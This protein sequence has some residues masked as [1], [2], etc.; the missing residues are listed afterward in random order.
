MNID[1]KLLREDLFPGNTSTYQRLRDYL[2]EGRVTGFTGAGVSVPLYPSW[3]GLLGQLLAEAKAAGTLTQVDEVR[4]CESLLHR[5]PLELADILEERIT[6]KVFRSRL[7]AIFRSANDKCTECQTLIA[8]LDLRG[9]VTLNYDSGHE[10][11]YAARGRNPNSGTAQSEFTLTR[12]AQDEVFNDPDT[13]ILHLHGERSDPQ[14]MVLTSTDYDTFYSKSL[15][16]AFISHLWRA[17]RLLAIGFGFSDPFLTRLA[18]GTLRTLPSDTRHYALIGQGKDQP[19]SGLTRSLFVKK[20]RLEP[21]FYEILEHDDDGVPRQDHSNLLH[22]LNGLA[23]I[24]SLYAKKNS[25]A[26]P[27]ARVTE[28]SEPSR[29]IAEKEFASD[30]FVAPNGTTLYSEPRFHSME[31]LDDFAAPVEIP[32]IEL[33][34]ENASYIITCRPEHGATTVSRRLAKELTQLG[35]QACLRDATQ[36]PNYKKKLEE[37]FSNAGYTTASSDNNVLILDRVEIVN[38]ERLIREI[39]GTGL[40]SRLFLLVS[41][42]LFETNGT[43]PSDQFDVCFKVVSLSAMTRADIRTLT[44]QFYQS[45]DLDTISS[46]V[47]KVYA[48]LVTLCIPTT[49]A[50]VIMYLSILFKDGDFQPIN[51]VQIVNK[52]LSDLLYSPSD[53]YREVFNARNK[54]DVISAFVFHLHQV[55]KT[56]FSEADWFVF[57]RN[58]M[59]SNLV[60]FDER[61]LLI[62]LKATRVLV[63]IGGELFFKYRF[64][65]TFFLGRH[66]ANRPSTMQEIIGDGQYLRH[67][68]LVEVIAELSSDNEPL[69]TDIVSKLESALAAFNQKYVREDFDPLADAVW[70]H[71]KDDEE[72]LWKPLAKRMEAGPRNAKEIDEIKSSYFNEKNAARQHV[73][74]QQFDQME[75]QLTALHNAACEV[76][77]CSDNLPGELKL[78]AVKV[79]LGAYFRVLQIGILLSSSIAERPMVQWHNLH[80]INQINDKETDKQKRVLNVVVNLPRAV[81]MKAVDEFGSKKLGEVFKALSSSSDLRGFF[82]VLNFSC[83]IRAKP[84]DW[85]KSAT[86]VIADTKRSE[87]YLATLLN[88]AFRQFSEEINTSS[89]KEQIKRL[90]AVIKAKRDLG[91]QNPGAKDIDYFTRELDQKHFFEQPTSKS[92]RDG[93]A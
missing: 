79:V 8:N 53:A 71:Q 72:K 22:L 61:N 39:L 41:Q 80:F 83:L 45:S 38:H 66:I 85:F 1:G 13:P 46:I 33:L 73:V 20:Y 86:H 52:Y 76:M 14:H 51:R 93:G 40:F 42:N 64:F 43:V 82:R 34:K 55:N 24:G 74:V 91:K 84:K 77:R 28:K 69:V 37:V 89:E 47:E 7:S 67:Q 44:S 25:P 57:C 50:N 92:I 78:R 58:F 11:A 63:P 27:V 4:E 49:P 54:M 65:H 10:I 29:T 26:F 16:Q 9:I 15:S 2:S 23:G 56:R 32:L 35:K 48:D 60:H 81:V 6:S 62:S 18:E 5:D 87:F 88:S 36:L 30:L 31:R 19:V 70:P 59:S 75:R 12:W 21:V 90:I 3:V 68:G 17:H